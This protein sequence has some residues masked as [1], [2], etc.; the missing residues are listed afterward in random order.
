M[1][2]APDEVL[3][4]LDAANGTDL[5]NVYVATVIASHK[6]VYNLDIPI[7]LVE[8]EDNYSFAFWTKFSFAYPNRLQEYDWMENDEELVLGR[9]TNLEIDED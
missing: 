3:A 5:E 8:E 6:A 9:F 7:E 2:E 1:S 4:A